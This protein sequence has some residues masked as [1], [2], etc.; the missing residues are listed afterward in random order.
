MAD[1]KDLL[2][3]VQS[4]QGDT[5]QIKSMLESAL[6]KTTG[7]KT[8][9]KDNKDVQG[10]TQELL[11]HFE[12]VDKNIKEGLDKAKS[13]YEKVL[14]FH[15]KEAD[16]N[17]KI[18][19]YTV[20]S[21]DAIAGLKDAMRSGSKSVGY[22]SKTGGISGSK[23][24]REL[25]FTQKA[26]GSI[27]SGIITAAG[28]T[29]YLSALLAG[30][31]EQENDF[32]IQMRQIAFQIDG[33]NGSMREMQNHWADIG[34]VVDE[35]GK[36]VT[37]FQ[38]TLLKQL[39]KGI[40]S[41]KQEEET[42]RASLN[43]STMLGMDADQ[44][45]DTFHD[46]QMSLNM[47]TNQMSQMSRNMQYVAKW[48][49]V[50][51]SELMNAVKSS[52][53]FMKNMR[54]AGTLTESASGHVLEM[55]AI[56]QKI[57][58]A[59]EMG[60][61]NNALSS[62]VNLFNSASKETQ[63]LLFSAASSMGRISDLQ[64]GTLLNTRAGI[65]DFGKGLE[66]S[67]RRISGV[68][69]EDIDK[70]DPD[71]LW[72]I[73]MM[74]QS[75]YG[76]QIGQMKKLH[77]T[78]VDAG[79]GFADRLGDVNK[80]LQNS[81]IT[82]QERIKLESD[83]SKLQLQA[84]FKFLSAFDS[85][86]KEAGSNMGD[87]TQKAMKQLGPD[88]E[89]DFQ[90]MGISMA[91]PL[92]GV[93]EY[94]V[95]QLR[96]AGGADF[97]G[98]LQKA[99]GSK[100]NAAIRD[101]LGKMNEEQRK[102]G[103]KEAARLDPMLEAAQAT[104]KANEAI[105]DVSR[106][107][108]RGILDSL[109]GT[110]VIALY[111][112]AL[113]AN[114]IATGGVIGKVFGKVGSGMA[115]IFGKG[116]EFF[117]KKILGKGVASGA[118]IAEVA[119]TTATTAAGTTAGAA[120]TGAAEGGLP[121]ADLMKKLDLKNLKSMGV[122]LAKG[123]LAMAL[124]T[125]G[126][127]LIAISI[128]KLSSVVM[129][130][131]N[132]TPE[133][134]LVMGGVILGLVGMMVAITY[135]VLSMQ[136]PLKE[137]GKCLKHIPRILLGALVLGILGAAIIA[138]A[139]GLVAMSSGL[140]KMSGMG[141]KTAAETAWA[142]SGILGAAG[143]IAAEVL[144]GATALGLLGLLVWKLPIMLLLIAGGALV[145]TALTPAIV[146]LALA[147]INFCRRVTNQVDMDSGSIKETQDKLEAIFDCSSKLMEIILGKK[148][149]FGNIGNFVFKCW[150][151]IPS[152]TDVPK[153]VEKLSKPLVEFAKSI[154]KMTEGL[155]LD[156]MQNASAK[157]RLVP[158][159]V[160]ILTKSI[161]TFMDSLV[162]LCGEAGKSGEV[163]KLV[164]A[165]VRDE[166]LAKEGKLGEAGG[167]ITWAIKSI[168]QF[169][170]DLHD[171]ISG[172]NE[173]E[174]KASA[175]KLLILAS[176][177]ESLGKSIKSFCDNLVPLVGAKGS[178]QSGKINELEHALIQKGKEGGGI[179]WAVKII[180]DFTE[181]LGPILKN[182]NPEEL[183]LIAKKMAAIG[184]VT[185]A[186]A[187]TLFLFMNKLVTF[188]EETKNVDGAKI[189][190]LDKIA[191][192]TIPL[193]SAIVFVGDFAQ[194]LGPI[195]K[196]V[197]SRVLVSTAIKLASIGRVLDSLAGSLFIFNDKLATFAT[198][199][200]N[201]I[202]AAEKVMDQPT[203]IALSC[204]LTN[205]AY[206]IKD[207]VIEPLKNV[208]K[209]GADIVNI[210]VA[211]YVLEQIGK[212]VAAMVPAM[213]A[214]ADNVPKL[215]DAAIKLEKAFMRSEGG[216]TSN[217]CFDPNNP[218]SV[219]ISNLG[220]FISKGLIAPLKLAFGEKGDIGNIG[221]MTNV[222]K[223]MGTALDALTGLMSSQTMIGL[224][225]LNTP[226]INFDSKT[227]QFQNFFGSFTDFLIKG[228]IGPLAV[229][230]GAF[231]ILDEVTNI[232]QKMPMS[233]DKLQPIISKIGQAGSAAQGMVVPSGVA[234][235]TADSASN[236]DRRMQAQWAGASPN[237]AN[238]ETS[239]IAAATESSVSILAQIRDKQNELVDYFTKKS[240]SGVQP[241]TMVRNAH[242]GP[243]MQ[244]PT[245][246]RA[247]NG[248]EAN[249]QYT[250]G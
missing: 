171:A 85:A 2:G 52:E 21:A 91:D 10:L 63:T 39:R 82:A 125:M 108:L 73:N 169:M 167:G 5:A 40:K 86:A 227:K 56:A 109:G 95:K 66:E 44:T 184:Q 48:T 23:K 181:N 12:K 42:L 100:D 30:A 104:L 38:N 7:A 54:N 140:L 145:M 6:S 209:T 229:L 139:I 43:L 135:G 225:S 237:P 67:F 25:S 49:G 179:V 16:S 84:G 123:A 62:T 243:S 231:S 97:S 117:I 188:A 147:L 233:M 195:L 173:S 194:K 228:V 150:N 64:K 131:V 8:I 222:L 3:R 199:K 122:D 166:K 200:V 136:E 249:T 185:D 178:W 36:N 47:S 115:S 102:L 143:V 53:K 221:V 129:K 214:M 246:D 34:K 223:L 172:V 24:E 208:F 192:S 50:T 157:L 163:N 148:S 238:G 57:G 236:V 212:I 250:I 174:S 29:N 114:S 60:E 196:D 118:K 69:F 156:K 79:K 9:R 210:G 121:G 71:R 101:L 46:W 205:L 183:N 180:R 106:T 190:N 80:Q 220:Q 96:A 20:N 177:S 92:R 107:M 116:K 119:G 142:V 76:M 87:A 112:A 230:G 98:D 144:A 191:A 74:L 31:I 11:R 211:A 4:V 155:D 19:K 45:A 33:I 124:V 59:D 186:L 197:D 193:Q 1:I 203:A 68:A 18:E 126:L 204:A 61:L 198:V 27:S 141:A 130:L 175:D 58:I 242:K 22:G 176:I 99:L 245:W 235:V 65:K 51:G 226:N 161:K 215:G 41:R 240:G 217:K 128:I 158:E 160:G 93:A 201:G 105:R 189:K 83:K 206:F 244:P 248:S 78:F 28:G 17:K 224:N 13:F 146:G 77:E 138:L 72:Q 88:M 14:Q 55:S 182:V 15:Q 159:I 70:I 75:A 137:L 216:Y 90:A 152:L 113:L 127:T 247:T 111:L 207:G 168:A 103:V 32:R 234:N 134:A 110:G 218:I 219:G 26:V 81:N 164:H 120:A 151:I 149:F 154:I 187:G 239:R 202:T 153:V 213:I 165:L 162:P 133:D 170:S 89:K 132:M 37:V 94:T 232:L 241:S 35:T